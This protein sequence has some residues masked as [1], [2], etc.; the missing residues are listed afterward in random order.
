[1]S[2]AI[3]HT[4]LVCSLVEGT[5][6]DD[7]MSAALEKQAQQQYVVTVAGVLQKLLQV[8]LCHFY[9]CLLSA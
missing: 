7:C 3:K 6:L 5:V 1:M 2:A 9:K 8:D 4:L